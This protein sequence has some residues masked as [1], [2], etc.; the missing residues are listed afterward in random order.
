MSEI[1]DVLDLL[2]YFCF[3]YLVLVFESIN[4]ILPRTILKL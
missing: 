1:Q 3:F 2:K 4:Q